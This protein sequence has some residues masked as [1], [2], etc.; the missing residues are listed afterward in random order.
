MATNFILER[1]EF[2]N[3]IFLFDASMG[4]NYANGGEMFCTLSVS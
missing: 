2:I 4:Q 1:G 3:A